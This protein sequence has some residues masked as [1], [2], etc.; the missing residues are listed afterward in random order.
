MQLLL[1]SESD[2]EGDHSE[3]ENGAREVLGTTE[4]RG[5]EVRHAVLEFG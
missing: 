5:L 4:A 1:G 2:E 3:K